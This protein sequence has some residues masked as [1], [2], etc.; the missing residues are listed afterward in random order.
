MIVII[1]KKR[2]MIAILRCDQDNRHFCRKGI[3]DK[4]KV[5]SENIQSE[6]ANFGKTS[7]S[8]YLQI[9][10]KTVGILN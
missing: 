9:H 1:I 7:A 2:E 3:R 8:H 4:K 6:Y 5:L 10:T